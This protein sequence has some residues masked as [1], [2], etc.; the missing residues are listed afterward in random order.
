[1][2]DH[3]RILGII[4]IPRVVHGF[5][6]ARQGDGRNQPQLA[7]LLLEKVR[8]RTV[9]VACGLEP[10]HRA[11]PEFAQIADQTLIVRQFV[12]YPKPPS[13]CRPDGSI[14]TSLCF[15]AI[16]TAT[17]VALCGVLSVLVMAGDPPE[18]CGLHLNH[19]RSLN[20]RP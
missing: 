10:D 19:L 6:R 17:S 5:A 18:G 9:I 14:N 12:G 2:Q 1:M 15:L 4:L 7:A 13:A 11:W 16:S 20:P 3:L 8:Q